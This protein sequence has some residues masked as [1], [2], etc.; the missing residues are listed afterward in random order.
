MDTAGPG[1]GGG[2]TRQYKDSGTRQW[3]ASL[4]LY[5][6]AVALFQHFLMAYILQARI[7]LQDFLRGGGGA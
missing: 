5:A 2:E 4:G 3:M 1:C 6:E 7:G